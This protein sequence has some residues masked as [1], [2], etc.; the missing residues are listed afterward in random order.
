MQ[1]LHLPEVNKNKI[2]ILHRDIKPS[3]VFMDKNTNA[4]L[5]DFG[6]SKILLLNSNI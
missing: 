6:L 5:G 4:K 3:N 2:I 1:Y